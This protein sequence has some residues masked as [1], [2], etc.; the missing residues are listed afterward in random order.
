MP[1]LTLVPSIAAVKRELAGFQQGKPLKIVFREGEKLSEPLRRFNEY[2]MPE[3]QINQL[4]IDS[5]LKKQIP[6]ATVL[7]S[8][9][10]VFVA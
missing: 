4:F 2:R 3:N 7:N 1:S 9:L 8:D 10:T 6:M 5:D